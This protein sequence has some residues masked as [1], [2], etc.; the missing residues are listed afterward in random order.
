MPDDCAGGFARRDERTQH[1]PAVLRAVA[2]IEEH[3]VGGIGVDVD[4]RQRVVDAQGDGLAL[5]KRQ[6]LR[7]SL[8]L[9]PILEVVGLFGFIGQRQD[10]DHGIVGG[11]REDAGLGSVDEVSLAHVDGGQELQVEA[12]AAGQFL[13]QRFVEIDADSDAA[14][15]RCDFK[16]VAEIEGREGEIGGEAVVRLIG[17]AAFEGCHQVPLLGGRHQAHVAIGGDAVAVE[18]HLH[19]GV[20]LV[21]EDGMIGAVVQKYAEPLGVEVILVGHVHGEIGAEQAWAGGQG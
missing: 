11:A 13:R 15:F 18:N 3:E 2:P 5:G 16:G 4:A 19:G 12:R 17:V 10:L 9:V 6:R 21:D 20:L 14:W 7:V 8:G 1:E